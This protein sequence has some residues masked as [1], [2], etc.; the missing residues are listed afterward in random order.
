GAGRQAEPLQ[1]LEEIQRNYEGFDRGV[2]AVMIQAGSEAREKGIFGLVADVVTV[3]PRF[4]R[5]IEAALGE[6]LQHIV[7]ESRNKGL[8]LIEFLKSAAEGRSTFLPLKS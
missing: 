3:T 2:R 5:A 6:K 8:E 7:V 1:S 4:E